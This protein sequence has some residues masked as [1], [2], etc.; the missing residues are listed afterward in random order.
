MSPVKRAARLMIWMI[1][2]GLIVI[3]G[4]NVSLEFLN[5]RL[6]HTELNLGRCLFWSLPVVV[7]FVLLATAS[8][9]A[10]RITSESDE[11]DATDE[12]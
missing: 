10:R 5:R 11:S 9:I 2:A 1:A 12:E 3:G 4:L 7:G 8:A 6:H